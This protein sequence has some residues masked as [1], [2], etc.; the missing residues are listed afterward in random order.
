MLILLPMNLQLYL[1]VLQFYLNFDLNVPIMFSR[2]FYRADMRCTP[3]KSL[4][5]F[6]ILGLTK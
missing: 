5:I 3:Y 1:E 2:H 4:R 6:S